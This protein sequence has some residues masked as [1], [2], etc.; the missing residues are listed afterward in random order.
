MCINIVNAFV[1]VAFD[2]VIVREV[3][4]NRGKKHD[5]KVC[6]LNCSK[7]ETIALCQAKRILDI[8]SS[9]EEDEERNAEMAPNTHL[10]R[11]T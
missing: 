1:I 7:F 11:M 8:D 10:I 4:V 9:S 5:I 6:L 3:S 2:A